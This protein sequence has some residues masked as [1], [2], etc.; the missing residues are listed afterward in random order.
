MS[1]KE[2]LKTIKDADTST[3]K[4]SRL[5]QALLRQLG[6]PRARVVSGI[7]Y[8]EGKGTIDYPPSSI[9]SWASIILKIYKNENEA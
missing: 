7:V 3:E 8:A 1:W 2:W 5:M 9:H 4:D 6:Y